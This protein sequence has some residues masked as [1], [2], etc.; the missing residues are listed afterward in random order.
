MDAG[1]EGDVAVALPVEDHGVGVLEHI[2]VVVG[3]GEVHEDLVARLHGDAAVLDGLDGVAG[4]GDRG[5]EAQQFLDG[6]IPEGVIGFGHAT[7]VVFV[8]GE[9]PQRRAD[10]RP[11][12]VDA[13]N[14]L[15]VAHADHDLVGQRLTV[16]LGLAEGGDEV[17]PGVGPAVDDLRGEEV[18]DEVGALQAQFWV[19]ESELEDAADPADEV[20]D[21]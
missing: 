17:V 20:V 21:P 1:A 6:G 2:G 12:G 19:G 18:P 8:A 5:V 4:H 7:A 3:S 9:V 15:Q 13:G 14:Q 11:G 10:R 16:D